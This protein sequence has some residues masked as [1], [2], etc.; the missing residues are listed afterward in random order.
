M[1]VNISY[2]LS[3]IL[4]ITLLYGCKG[5]KEDLQVQ[6][7]TEYLSFQPGKY[8]TY[9]LDSTVFPEQGRA[10]AVRSYQEKHVV[11]AQITDNLGRPSYRIFRYIRDSAGLQAWTPSGTYFIT[12]LA[13]SVEYIDDNLRV[14]KLANPIKEFGMWKGNRHLYYEPY[15]SL[16]DFSNDDNMFDWNYT[17]ESTG[18]TE[19]YFGKTY[20]DVVTIIGADEA[21]NVPITQA[22]AYAS[23]SLLVE[24][25]SKGLGMIFQEYILWEY[26][27]NPG[28]SPYKTGFGVKRTIIDNN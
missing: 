16:Y 19:T 15:V 10:E 3:F 20:E 24:K 12:P 21:L 17:I 7:Y 5:D 14:V 27:P 2:L 26:Q 8:I 13:N 11:D 9:R 23:R 22:D 1:R 4:V 25:Y 18:G 28:S 6:S